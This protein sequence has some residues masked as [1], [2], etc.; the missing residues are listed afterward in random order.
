MQYIIDWANGAA[1][2]CQPFYPPDGYEDSR[3]VT[4]K[5]AQK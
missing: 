5:K 1:N 3:P 2:L 4:K